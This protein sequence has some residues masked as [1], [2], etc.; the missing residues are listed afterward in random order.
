MNDPRTTRQSGVSTTQPGDL[1]TPRDVAQLLRVELS[2]LRTWRH[3]R[4]GPPS[5]R[6]DSGAVR[7]DRDAVEAYLAAQKAAAA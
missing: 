5:Y 1:L 2:T 6:L 4:K 3:R 7:Y